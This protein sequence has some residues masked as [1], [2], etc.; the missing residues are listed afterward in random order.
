MHILLAS[1]TMDSV[2]QCVHCITR[3]PLDTGGGEGRG[4]LVHMLLASAYHRLGQC[5]HAYRN[6]IDIL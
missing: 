2:S 5:M 1:P 6:L 4:K 3:D